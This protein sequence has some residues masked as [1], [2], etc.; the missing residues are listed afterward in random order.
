MELEVEVE[1]EV[2]AEVDVG[3]LA[4]DIVVGGEHEHKLKCSKVWFGRL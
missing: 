4:G 1:A 2:E 3:A